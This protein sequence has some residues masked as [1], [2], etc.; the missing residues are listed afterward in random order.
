MAKKSDIT[1]PSNEI[2]VSLTEQ[3]AYFRLSLYAA[4]VLIFLLLACA[5]YIDTETRIAPGSPLYPAKTNLETVEYMASQANETWPLFL[6]ANLIEK[7]LLEM[8]TLSS[9]L[10]ADAREEWPLYRYG[11]IKTINENLNI[12]IIKT[13]SQIESLDDTVRHLPLN[14][15]DDS[16]E[17]RNLIRFR[18][19]ELSETRK[20]ILR[21]VLENNG[22]NLEEQLV[23]KIRNEVETEILQN[24]AASTEQPSFLPK[25]AGPLVPDK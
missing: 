15:G 13:K 7:R 18:V 23:A 5:L 3:T 1:I 6:R 4:L 19:N 11:D 12:L 24:P 8:L 20:N 25:A 17:D 10:S 22:N 14:T 16:D 9:A 2:R 21:K